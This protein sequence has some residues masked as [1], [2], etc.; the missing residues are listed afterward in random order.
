MKSKYLSLNSESKMNT[1]TY[2]VR[3]LIFNYV[4]MRD[5][6]LNFLKHFFWEKYESGIIK[7]KLFPSKWSIF[8]YTTIQIKNQLY[9]LQKWITE[10]S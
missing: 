1:C 7:K 9:T 5:N 2:Y 3:P 4:F 10:Y 6:F 8:V